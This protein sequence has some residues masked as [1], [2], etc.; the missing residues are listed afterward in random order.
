M[1]GACLLAFLMGLDSTV[2][3]TAI[4]QIT[5]EFHSPAD[6]GWYGSAYLLL[7][8][9]FQPVYGRAY[10]HFNVRWTYFVALGAFLIGSLIC[11][12]APT[13][14]ALVVGR[15]LAGLGCAGV[16]AGNL[17]IVALGAPLAKRPIFISLL[18]ATYVLW[19]IG[20]R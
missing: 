15:A 10:T 18:G 3:T 1:T 6:V 9:T 14:A 19:L 4:P 13:S 17:N 11:G 8:C 12:L 2:I 5:D 16:L 20:G 7:S